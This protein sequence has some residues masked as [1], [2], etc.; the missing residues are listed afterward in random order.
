MILVAYIVN[1]AFKPS[2]N[3]DSSNRADYCLEDWENKQ[4][5]WRLQLALGALPCFGL[6]LYGFVAPE[7]EVWREQASVQHGGGQHGEYGR[8]SEGPQDP[9]RSA[10]GFEQTPEQRLS[11][12]ATSPFAAD[13]DFDDL[14]SAR[15]DRG[16]ASLFSASGVKWTLI[17]LGLACAQQLTGINAI[18]FYSP[19]IFK[20]GQLGHVLVLTI[21]IVGLWNLLSVFPAVY[22]VERV[23]RRSLMLFGMS[24]VT[25]GA[26]LMTI[27]YAVL[28]GTAKTVVSV[29][30]I[31][32]FIARR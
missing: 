30:G 7:T 29:V 1:Y 3:P 8:L 4:L 26:L 14:Y 31:M 2:Y 25:L 10:G 19:E 15:A 13:G 5:Q 21:L 22:F 11:T 18:I 6:M 23:G 16:W 20:E 24:G 27:T 9:H 12:K 28:E 17:G 32:I